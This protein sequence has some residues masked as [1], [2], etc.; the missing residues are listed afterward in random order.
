MREFPE[1]VDLEESF[2]LK[3]Q[4]YRDPCT[5]FQGFASPSDPGPRHS[6]PIQLV[7]H[8]QKGNVCSL[9]TSRLN[10]CPFPDDAFP[11]DR[12]SR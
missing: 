1:S 6:L 4:V 9:D 7:S 3:T 5:A 12:S 11:T 8:D 2:L 10:E